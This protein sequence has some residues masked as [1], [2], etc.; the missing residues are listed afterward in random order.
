MVMRN[1]VLI[2]RDNDFLNME[3]E[4]DSKIIINCYN[5]KKVYIVQ[6]FY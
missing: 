6:L 2:I 5:K 3:T 1:D 4:R